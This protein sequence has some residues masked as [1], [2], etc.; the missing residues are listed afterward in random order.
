[1]AQHDL[2]AQGRRKLAAS[3]V[4]R[5]DGSYPITDSEDVRK[6]VDDW[7]RTGQSLA[8]K[9]W[10]EKRCKALGIPVPA[11]LSGKSDNDGDEMSYARTK[12]GASCLPTSPRTAH[13]PSRPAQRA[14]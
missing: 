1:M 2:S 14:R 12:G 7:N 4:A 11:A 8:V 9:S 6:A 3:G 13:S 5:P 10:I